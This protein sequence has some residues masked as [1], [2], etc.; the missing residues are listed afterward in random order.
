MEFTDT[1]QHRYW[2]IAR[3][4]LSFCGR[5][6]GAVDKTACA[7]LEHLHRSLSIP[8][9]H[10]EANNLNPFAYS[11]EHNAIESSVSFTAK[12]LFQHSIIQ[13][14]GM[15]SPF[16]AG[17]QSLFF[18]FLEQFIKSLNKYIG[19]RSILCTQKMVYA[20]EEEM[21]EHMTQF[22]LF[23]SMRQAV[24]DLVVHTRAF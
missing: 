8:R 19:R 23:R 17:S 15:F 22:T 12:I 18:S 3:I 2:F 21:Y 4:H 16:T 11:R 9:R 14:G 13:R 10:F 20:W 5:T 24:N 7:R 6:T 1:W